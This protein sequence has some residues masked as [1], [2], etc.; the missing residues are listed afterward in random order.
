MDTSAQHR[1]FRRVY[2]HRRPDGERFPLVLEADGTPA[3]YPTRLLLNLRGTNAAWGTME[4]AANDLLF[5]EQVQIFIGL[6]D[7]E[8]R[9]EDGQYLATDEIQSI[10]E[11]S[12]VSLDRLRQLNEPKVKPARLGQAFSKEHTVT[13]LVK[14]RRMTNIARYIDMIAKVG[15]SLVSNP[16]ARQARVALREEMLDDLRVRRPSF[17][18]S[19]VRNATEHTELA[20]VVEFVVKGNPEEIWFKGDIR[21]RNWAI[22]TLLAL[23]GLREG[24]LRQLKLQDVDTNR[25]RLTV[26]RRSDDQ[27]DPRLREPN[28]KTSDRV[29]PI[30]EII[31]DRIEEYLYGHQ[32]DAAELTGSNF[33]FLSHGPTS[34][35]RPISKEVVY[36]AVKDLGKH[37]DIPELHPHSL[38]AAWIQN[39][40]DWAHEHNVPAG[41]LDRFANYLGGWS[42]LSNMASQYRGDHLTKMAYQAGL[43]VE[44]SR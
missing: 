21:A 3:H 36:G 43:K 6:Q 8:Q 18:R 12:G 32:G 27:E 44:E 42:Y 19:R 10:S 13:N 20:R 33:L 7:L 35:G 22:V 23:A 15:E 1:K 38:R 37:L 34:L 29:Y 14:H 2:L 5:L 9:I 25:G 26:A 28:A 17:R 41:E 40:V 4:V 39:L 31:S 24:E 11:L 16:I 30:T